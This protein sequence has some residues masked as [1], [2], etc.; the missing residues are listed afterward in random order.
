MKKSFIYYCILYSVLSS[1]FPRYKLFAFTYCKKNAS[2]IVKKKTRVMCARFF[3]VNVNKKLKN[4]LIYH[5]SYKQSGQQNIAKNP[6]KIP[7]LDRYSYNLFILDR[8][9]TYLTLWIDVIVWIDLRASNFS[10]YRELCSKELMI[11]LP[12]H[13]LFYSSILRQ[14]CDFTKRV[15]ERK[16]IV[17][18]VVFNV[19]TSS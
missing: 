2:R 10:A 16:S 11:T 6:H 17:Y 3:L 15:S 12:L 5:Q 8:H 7:Q 4:L 9:F 19:Y 13:G 14:F 1:C 18:V